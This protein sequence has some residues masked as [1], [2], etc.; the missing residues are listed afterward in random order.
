[1]FSTVVTDWP[2]TPIEG[3]YQTTTSTPGL[4][5]DNGEAA[6]E[7]ATTPGDTITTIRSGLSTPNNAYTT[8]TDAVAGEETT[9][10]SWTHADGQTTTT[11]TTA[12]NNLSVTPIMI[13]TSDLDERT[14]SDD[15]D[16]VPTTTTTTT[17]T[18]GGLELSSTSEFWGDFGSESDK[19]TTILLPSAET[20]TS[21]TDSVTLG[22]ATT[23]KAAS[24]VTEEVEEKD[25]SSGAITT[26]TMQPMITTTMAEAG[27]T[28]EPTSEAPIATTTAQT[29]TIMTTKATTRA[30]W[31][32]T[33]DDGERVTQTGYP[34]PDFFTDSPQTSST[35]GDATTEKSTTTTTQEGFESKTTT[36]AKPFDGTITNFTLGLDCKRMPCLNGGTCIMTSGGAKVS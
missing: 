33:M 20:T 14:P 10:T 16:L 5:A 3:N 27:E 15:N 31:E 17:T 12:S 36:T 19:F 7:V 25:S 1:M 8:T 34:H 21:R 26:Q 32:T 22:P 23:T 2:I 28:K 30:D 29:K 35:G 18:V 9:T 13:T 24:P 4:T 11:K 6:G